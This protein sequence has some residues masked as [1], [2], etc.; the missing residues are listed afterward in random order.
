MSRASLPAAAARLSAAE[1][2]RIIAEELGFAS[3]LGIATV[4]MEAGAAR[5]RLPFRPASLRPGGTV[6]G[7]AMMTLADVTMYAV[8]LGAIGAVKLAVTTSLTI[9]FL[10]R[11]PPVELVGVGRLL[12][13]GRRLAV[14]EVAIAADVEGDALVAHATGTYSIP[15]RTAEPQ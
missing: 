9:N 11:P 3:A 7:P 5:L 15:A 1:F 8:V 12:K 6:S 13:L 10:R 2:D 4:A 14:I